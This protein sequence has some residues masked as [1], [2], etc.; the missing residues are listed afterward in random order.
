[1]T[2]D[3]RDET[4]YGAY[5]SVCMVL[6]PLAAVVLLILPAPA[7]L[8]PKAWATAAVAVWMAVWWASEAVP[9][10]ATALL[11]LVL[12]P[13]LGIHD[14]A[15]AAAPFANPLIFLFLGGFLIALAMQRWNLHR[16]IA[17]HIVA[18]AGSRPAALIGGIMLATACLS[19]WISNTA[20]AMMMMPI[21]ASLVTI[22]RPGDDAPP[23]PDEA[24]FATALMLATAYAAS[25]GGLGTLVGSPPNALLAGF[26]A[27]TY[28]IEVGFARWMTIGLPVV[29]VMLPLA[30][31]VLTKVVFRFRLGERAG[32]GPAIA[33]ALRAMG[34]MSRP[35]KR[36]AIVF[37]LVAALWITHPLLAPWIGR[38][39][40]SDAGVAI[41]GALLMFVI[42]A[43]WKKRDFLLDWAWATRAPWAILILFGGGLSLAQAVDKTGLA[44]WIGGGLAVL[45]DWPVILLVAAVACLVIF[46][47]ELTSN[48]ATTAA[49][50]PVVG[51]VAVQAGLD[52][53]LLTVPAAL[54]ASCAFML[55]V[56]TPPNAI[57]FGSGYV[58][59]PQMMRAG[60][61][62]N[63]I[64][65]L[66]V[67]VVARLVVRVT[68]S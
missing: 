7:G 66:V 12:F 60:L 26:M 57:V 55:P 38:G 24:R 23:G 19:M 44:A 13:L 25:I 40:V 4:A 30:W 48:T 5:R 50:L 34:P 15:K 8:D 67:T 21:A 18:L 2:G 58:T 36:V 68:L 56:A 6:G 9:V 47:T 65:I 62:L 43:D 10:A 64:G 20:T 17:L 51:A 33:E 59:I 52:P 32:A 61:V 1:M 45:G 53:L 46:L 28:G 11:P 37:A 35:E 27:Q 42:P 49:F 41:A 63:L 29:A 22:V 14:I 16:R 54:A 39:A 31:L 3:S